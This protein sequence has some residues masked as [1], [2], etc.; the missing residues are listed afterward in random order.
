MGENGKTIVAAQIH[1]MGE[2][3]KKMPINQTKMYLK[4]C[5]TYDISIQFQNLSHA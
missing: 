4:P 1:F 2:N 5:L 3:G